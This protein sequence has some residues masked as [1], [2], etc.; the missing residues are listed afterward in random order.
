MDAKAPDLTVRRPHAD[1]FGWIEDSLRRLERAS[2]TRRAEPL[3]STGTAVD[4][5]S[6]DYLGMALRPE[7]A[8]ACAGAAA[9]FGTGGRASRVVAGGCELH[10][11]L[12]ETLAAMC[13]AESAVVF[14]SGYL[15]NIGTVTAL[16]RSGSSLVMDE[17]N[18]ASLVDGA[19]LSGAVVTT[20]A[21]GDIE[22]VA[23]ALERSGTKR[24]AFVTES[25]FSVDGDMAQLTS[26]ADICA[27]AG[28]GLI[29]DDAHGFGVVGPRGYG[30]L[31]AG[32][33]RRPG[34]VGIVTL[35]KALGTQ[36]GAVVGSRRVIDHLVNVARP[37]IFDTALAPPSAAAALAALRILA[38]EP[39]RPQRLRSL[40]VDMAEMLQRAGMPVST[41]GGAVLS[42]EAPSAKAA[43]AWAEECSRR[44]VLV[45]CFRPPAVPEGKS[46]LRL[47]LH[48]DLTEDALK[49]GA[50][51]V[52]A[53]SPH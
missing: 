28:A 25:V 51:T 44:G 46:R 35:S 5:T 4:L 6:N 27:E 48:A 29:I 33:G 45:G 3:W 52:V 37:F 30:S 23:T 43:S 38:D 20:V 24:A 26:L 31:A 14:S 18:H 7:L 22:A 11:E 49:H 53:T 47:S 13:G 40:V 1:A 16:C 36:G 21:H 50:E 34:V 32:L 19:R 42:V 39:E 15:A 2:L 10:R 17:F 41:P 8:E 12:E 9:R